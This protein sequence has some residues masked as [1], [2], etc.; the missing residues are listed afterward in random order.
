M[1][2]SNFLVAGLIAM[3]MA[4]GLIFVGCGSKCDNDGKCTGNKAS[5][6]SCSSSSCAV[7]GSDTD[8]KCDC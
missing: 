6:N 4:G 3:L 5:D 8:T 7:N 2:K 1:K